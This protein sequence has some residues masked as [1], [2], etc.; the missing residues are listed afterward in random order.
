MSRMIYSKF[1]NDRDSSLGIITEIMK[2]DEQ[3][4]V[5]KR[6]YAPAGQKHIDGLLT[7]YNQLSDL[8]V[9]S[10]FRANTCTLTNDSAYFEYLE[11]RTLEEML[12]DCLL[13]GDM[14]G[15]RKLADSFVEEV[16]KIYQAL[17]FQIS[18]DFIKVFGEV[19][20]S[21]SVEASCLINVDL[22]FSNIIVDD[23]NWQVMD[24]EWVFDF[25]IPINFL[26]YRAFFYYT[27]HNTKR[28]VLLDDNT[29]KLFGITAQE[30]VQYK[31]MD[32]HFISRYV[33]GGKNSIFMFHH[34]MGKQ[35]ISLDSMLQA[36]KK[37]TEKLRCQIFYDYGEG[38]CEEDSV[39]VEPKWSNVNSCELEIVLP[40][41][42]K[43]IRLDP[44]DSPCML[45]IIEALQ[46][47]HDYNYEA[48]FTSNSVTKDKKMLLFT[49]DD[50]NITITNLRE[51][52]RKIFIRLDYESYEDNIAKA[53]AKY[54]GTKNQK[55]ERLTQRV[56]ELSQRIEGVENAYDSV[57]R[58]GSWRVTRPLR[59]MSEKVKRI[60]VEY[61]E[62]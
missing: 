47:A 10:R 22:L 15:F 33:E 39:I 13:S 11:G 59:W 53:L 56:E 30:I 21:P 43:S 51:D 58:S 6:A 61:G 37:E 62:K 34:L 12:D 20:L 40:D 23:S 28:A 25:L 46:M 42:I 7:K 48:E 29:M 50:P 16:K 57:M 19:D 2:E 3:L 17:P 1:S 32:I 31:K 24:Y 44:G 60:S 55:E 35:T 5:R 8:F 18:E 27:Q 36:Y 41:K 9:G 4:T 38:F 26:I 14:T 49:T 45:M 52:A 54:H